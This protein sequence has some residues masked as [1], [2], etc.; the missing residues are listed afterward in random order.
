MKTHRSLR[1]L[2]HQSG[3]RMDPTIA[4][5][6]TLTTPKEAMKASPAWLASSVT[7]RCANARQSL[8]QEAAVQALATGRTAPSVRVS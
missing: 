4:S 5:A 8:R 1:L 7:L 2:I 3:S 6:G